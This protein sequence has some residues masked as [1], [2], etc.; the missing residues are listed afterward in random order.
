MNVKDFF[1]YEEIKEMK[2]RNLSQEKIIDCFREL[3]EEMDVQQLTFQ[4]LAKRLDIKSPSLYNYFKNIRE[5][6]TALTAQLLRELNDQLLRALVGKSGAEALRIYAKTYQEFAFANRA[7]YELLISI[8][9]TNEEILLD[10]IHETNQIILQIFEVFELTNEEKVHRSREL[11][12]LIHGYL[13]LR[14]LG[15]FTR[16]PQVDPEESYR[17]MIEDFI[18]TLSSKKG[19]D[20]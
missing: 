3:A 15:Y 13:S 12:S 16:E 10:G 2:K 1:T 18:A 7:V 8:P 17:W 19:L 11:R 6:K 20:K 4:H 9:H 5:V 14:F